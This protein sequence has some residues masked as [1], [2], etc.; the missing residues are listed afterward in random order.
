[1][2]GEVRMGFLDHLRELRNRVVWALGGYAVAVGAVY[3]YRVPITEWLLRPYLHYVNTGVAV[4]GAPRILSLGEGLAFDMKLAVWGGL[5]AGAPWIAFQL[6]RFIRP[7]LKPREARLA[8][9]VLVTLGV[10][11][12]AGVL[13]AWKYLLPPMFRF[14]IE[15]NRG[16]FEPVITLSSL[17]E[18]ESR[19]MFWSGLIFEMPVAAFLLGM[20]G[21]T[22]PG[23]LAK[24]WRWA[25]LGAFILGAVI[26]PTSDPVN[27]CLMAVPIL[28]LYFLSIAT[29]AAGRLLAGRKPGE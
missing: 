25:I 4:D 18:M 27:M 5:V 10:L 11:F 3:A 6:W 21:L 28:L 8:L 9:P 20:A 22:R 13:F 12:I 26:T 2:S 1:M 17:W 19:F 23:T 7:A 15:Y 14:F 16:R 24:V 29:C